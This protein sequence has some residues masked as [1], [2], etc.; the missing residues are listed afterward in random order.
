MTTGRPNSAMAKLMTRAASNLVFGAAH[1][2]DRG[3]QPAFSFAPDATISSPPT[4]RPACSLVR[5]LQAAGI[6]PR[7]RQIPQG[8]SN[9]PPAKGKSISSSSQRCFDCRS[10][11]AS[12][13]DVACSRP[14]NSSLSSDASRPRV[15]AP[16]ETL[17]FNRKQFPGTI[18]PR[19]DGQRDNSKPSQSC[20]PNM[21]K[22]LS[23]NAAA[24]SGA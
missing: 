3:G 9:H 4:A 8:S 5:V 16:D 20:C 15:N 7:E 10:R 14:G 12:G 17:L 13:P 21:P 2:P 11:S 23:T 22:L 19:G 24:E 18:V 6:M 1:G